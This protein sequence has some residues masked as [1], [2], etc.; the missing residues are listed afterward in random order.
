MVPQFLVHL[1]WSVAVATALC[2]GLAYR[3]QEFL[4]PA[5]WGYTLLASGV[6]VVWLVLLVSTLLHDFRYTYIWGHSSR[7]LP[8]ELLIS[9]TY[10]GQEGSLLLWTLWLALVGLVLRAHTRRYGWEAPTMSIYTGVLA[11]MLLLLVVK[12][13][14]AFVW[15]TYAEQGVTEGFVPSDGRGLN[16]LL[17]NYWIVLHPPTLFLGFTLLTPPFALAL[18][19]LWQR[20]YQS[21]VAMALPWMGVAAA[22]L[23]LGIMLGGVWAY[24]TLGWGGFWAWDPVENSSLVPWLFLVAGIHTAL[25]QRRSG[26]LVRTTVVLVVLGFLA[27]L[28]STFLTRSGVLGDTSVH[29]F[30]DPGLFAY[31]LLIALMVGGVGVS[32]AFLLW[33]WRELGQRALALSTNSRELAL[34][35]G[36]LGLVISAIVVLVG[37]SYPIV[38]ELL[39]RPKVAVEQR[40]YN[41]L[42]IPIGIWLFMLN[43]LSLLLQWRATPQRLFWKRL[44]FPLGLAAVS[45]LGLW[46]LGVRDTALVA[47]AAS[48]WF[49]IAVNGRILLQYLRR[50][51]QTLG[52]W[53]SHAGIALLTIG[54]LVLSSLSWTAHA[55][56]PYNEPVQLG[57]YRLTYLGR[58]QI[59]R[60]YTDREK[61]RYAVQIEHGSQR[62]LVF[63]VLFWSDYNQRQAAFLEPG[64]QWRLTAD[65]YV[66]PKAVETEG[67]AAELV[68]RRGESMPLPLDSG[69]QV[70]LLRFAMGHTPDDTL[71]LGIWIAV[72]SA[73][74]SDTLHLEAQMLS[75]ERFLP[76]W[77]Q[78]GDSLELALLRIVPNRQDLSRSQAVL[79]VRRPGAQ[80]REVFTVEFSLKPGINLVWLGALLTVVGLA[81]SGVERLRR[82]PG[83]RKKVAV[84]AA[85][86]PSPTEVS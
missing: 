82:L 75:L 47:L 15:E 38:A 52:A 11:G 63:P 83:R 30:V 54:V 48:A 79:G 27:A 62:A 76:R 40:F 86:A 34:A 22:V 70:E 4:P 68:L 42:H 46:L 66:A 33:R 2:Y 57:A 5:R 1:V 28:Y 74:H 18:A 80:S 7:Q 84:A 32:A 69:R 71:T 53:L 16:P 19:G 20:Q 26:G 49:A 72:R 58:E 23:G 29:S 45:T 13:P 24:E 59:E 9:S 56:L 21:W 25:I 31:V 39:G 37:T 12:N 10:A 55:R 77:R 73:S 43:G 14:F 85:E 67:G 64:I 6:A 44:W 3:R 65:F 8:L 36:A 50:H 51:P 81:W 60:E 78:Y 61:W 35:L 41:L 17:H